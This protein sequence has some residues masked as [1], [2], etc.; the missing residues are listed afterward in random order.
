MGE[1]DSYRELP[2]TPLLGTSVNRANGRAGVTRLLFL[3]TFDDEFVDELLYAFL[4]LGVLAQIEFTPGHKL[5][6]AAHDL[7]ELPFIALLGSVGIPEGSVGFHVGFHVILGGEVDADHRLC[8]VR[9]AFFML[10]GLHSTL[11]P[12]GSSAASLQGRGP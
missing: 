10:A 12:F 11:T 9:V 7:N 8:G 5:S 4:L 2:R 3:I 1:G 6:Q